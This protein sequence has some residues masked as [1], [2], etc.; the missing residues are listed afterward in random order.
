MRTVLRRSADENS[1]QRRGEQ[2]RGERK[3]AVLKR[4]ALRCGQQW[5]GTGAVSQFAAEKEC[6]HACYERAL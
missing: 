1:E 3:R 6:H 2:C 5:H 4:A